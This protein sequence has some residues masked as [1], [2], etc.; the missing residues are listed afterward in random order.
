MGCGKSTAAGLFE[1]RGWRRLDSD[2]IVH[3]LLARDETTIGEVAE[4]F[5]DGV[6]K[7]GGGVDRQA[8]GRIVF[9]DP[10]RL[11]V[12]EAI[13]HP[14]V[15]EAWETASAQ[16]GNWVVEV[17]LLFEKKLE[18]RFDFAVCVSCHP[19]TQAGR[20]GQRGMDQAQALARIRRQM[21]LSEKI[22]L[23]DFA[24]LNDGS[25]GFLDRQ[26]ARLALHFQTLR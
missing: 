1:K 8:L 26:V 18:N 13:L 23:A 9:A 15:R 24:L 3:E 14:K 16:G 7:S 12:L 22:E 17:P 21:P 4:A 5:G 6:L 2:A 19:L 10:D 25:Y 11:A 20:L